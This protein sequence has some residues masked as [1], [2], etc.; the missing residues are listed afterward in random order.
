VVI[1]VF[2][3]NCVDLTGMLITATKHV[4]AAKYSGMLSMLVLV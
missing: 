3:L 2:P 4:P 1:K